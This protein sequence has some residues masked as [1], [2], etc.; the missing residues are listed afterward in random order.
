MMLFLTIINLS[1]IN[2]MQAAISHTR[3]YLLFALI[4]LIWGLSWPVSKI[5]VSYIPP[6]WFATARLVIGS[7]F[8]FGFL[9]IRK[10]LVLPKRKDLPLIIS[11]GLLQMGIFMA[12][13]N[14]GLYYTGVGHAA[15]IVYS[16]PLWVTPA[17]VLCFGERL[18]PLKLI[19]LLLGVAGIFFLFNPWEFDWHN[20]QVILGSSLLLLASICWA[21]AMLISRYATWHNSALNLLPWQLLV[22]AIP[23]I[24]AALYLEPNPQIEWHLSIIAILFYIG[25]LVTALGYWGTLLISKTLPVMTTS[26]CFLAAPVIG[27]ISSTYFLQEP[28]SYALVCAMILII[29]GLICIALSNNLA[30][31]KAENLNTAS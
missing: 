29:A 17:A 6:L 14:V 13:V 19:G 4:I 20:K 7:L 18:S 28:L 26:L 31:K 25:V 3:L 21:S 24:I 30:F 22:G 16:T 15:I 5:G 10:R 11:L 8:I 9:L 27:L 1:S 23:V 2:I 12:L